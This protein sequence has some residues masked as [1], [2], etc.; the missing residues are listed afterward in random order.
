MKL[1]AQSTS[2]PI[3]S[4]VKFSID[5]SHR[6]ERIP[7][8]RWIHKMWKSIYTKLSFHSNSRASGRQLRVNI[9]SVKMR[10]RLHNMI[11]MASWHSWLFWRSLPSNLRSKIILRPICA[12]S[13]V[14][15]VYCVDTS[16]VMLT[17]QITLVAEDE[18][19]ANLLDTHQ[20]IK[21]AFLQQTSG[22]EQKLF[23]CLWMKHIRIVL[24]Q[25]YLFDPLFLCKTTT[26]YVLHSWLSSSS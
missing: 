7:P 9:T 5:S 10:L 25:R 17:T 6:E 16:R 3:P 23:W 4:T 26:L 8:N 2:R 21:K 14:R 15:F 19:W 11:T 18:L 22:L 24:H 20:C 12:A 1:C 13:V